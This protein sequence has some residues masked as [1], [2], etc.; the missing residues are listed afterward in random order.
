MRK[1]VLAIK[2]YQEATGEVRLV[3]HRERKVNTYKR[4]SDRQINAISDAV[5]QAVVRNNGVMS[6]FRMGLGWVWYKD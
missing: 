5:A 4:R 2:L 1:D 6:P 3:V